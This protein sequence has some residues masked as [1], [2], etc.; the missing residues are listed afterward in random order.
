[1]QVKLSLVQSCVVAFALLVGALVTCG[2]CRRRGKLLAMA[3]TI[4]VQVQNKPDHLH[5]HFLNPAWNDWPGDNVF[6]FERVLR[7]I[8]ESPEFWV[9]NLEYAEYSFHVDN[10][11][12]RVT[13]IVV[14]LPIQEG[15]LETAD[16]PNGYC[17]SVRNGYL[18]FYRGPSGRFAGELLDIDEV[19]TALSAALNLTEVLKAR[20]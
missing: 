3:R 1:M 8:G 4:G 10:P 7:S 12:G 18:Y 19:P 16:I 2:V 15:I 5:D 17:I 14:A 13:V 6:R 20:R 11:L 9:V